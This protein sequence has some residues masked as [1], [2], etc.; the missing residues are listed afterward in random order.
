MSRP[1]ILNFPFEVLEQIAGIVN[2]NTQL[3][4][5]QVSKYFHSFTI[6]SLYR[7]ITL[8]NASALVA[9]C[10]VLSSNLNAAAAVRSFSITYT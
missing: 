5:C 8:V 9:C 7:H 6:R 10:H 3:S 1:S 2:L 4:L